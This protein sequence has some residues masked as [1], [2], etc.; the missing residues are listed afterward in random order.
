MKLKNKIIIAAIS[1][2]FIFL[3]YLII[4]GGYFR[5]GEKVEG[6]ELFPDTY[7][8]EVTQVIFLD[9]DETVYTV[10]D[11][12]HIQEVKD[13]LN[14]LT[15]VAVKNPEIEGWCLFELHTKNDVLEFSVSSDLFLMGGKTYYIAEED[16]GERL[17][18]YIKKT[19]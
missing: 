7:W 15:Y 2:C 4:N 17:S 12:K 13:M 19:S 6:T 1:I 3:L 11:P 9:F 5:N 8:D 18:E 10:T 16:V 14:S